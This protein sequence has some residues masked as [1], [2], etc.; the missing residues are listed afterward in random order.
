MTCSLL[1][2]LQWVNDVGG[3]LELNTTNSSNSLK[4]ANVF[5]QMSGK[6][7]SNLRVRADYELEQLLSDTLKTNKISISNVAKGNKVI[8]ERLCNKRVLLVIDD[9]NPLDQLNY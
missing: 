5:L 4:A 9:V 8:R 3:W 7:F 1:S 6:L 2:Q